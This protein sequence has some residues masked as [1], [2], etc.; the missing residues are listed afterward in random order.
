VITVVIFFF[1]GIE[2][3]ALLILLDKGG[4]CAAFGSF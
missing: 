1:H 2:S 3:E 4:I